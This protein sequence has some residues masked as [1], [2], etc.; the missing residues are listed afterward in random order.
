MRGCGDAGMRGCGDAEF[1]C[2]LAADEAGAGM[3]DTF[4][5]SW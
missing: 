1:T 2:V 4:G 5:A 3:F